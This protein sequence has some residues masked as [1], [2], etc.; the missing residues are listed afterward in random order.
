M[1]DTPHPHGLARTGETNVTECNPRIVAS[2]CRGCSRQMNNE[3]KGNVAIKLQD[4]TWNIPLS[5]ISCNWQNRWE[6]S[7]RSWNWCLV[8]DKYRDSR[9]WRLE[10]RNWLYFQCQR[11]PTVTYRDS[12]QLLPTYRVTSEFLWNLINESLVNENFLFLLVMRRNRWQ[13]ADEAECIDSTT[14]QWHA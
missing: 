1:R 11:K 4:N 10:C 9:N 5:N 14:K 3:F 7:Y 12:N 2:I 13:L 8:R 6:A